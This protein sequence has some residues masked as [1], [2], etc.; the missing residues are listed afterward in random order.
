[1]DTKQHAYIC[2]LQET[3]LRPRET[4]ILKVLEKRILL[5]N[6]N[7]NKS[8]A[9]VLISDKMHF[10]VSTIKIKKTKKDTT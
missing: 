4:Y 10:K 3:H 8:R 5:A 2:C 9:A 7:Q 6:G 1:M